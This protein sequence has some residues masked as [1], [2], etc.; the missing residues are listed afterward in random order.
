M[1]NVKRLAAVAIGVATLGLAPTGATA[2]H[3]ADIFVFSGLDAGGQR[4]GLNAG[5]AGCT[6][7]DEAVNTNVITPG[8]THAWVGSLSTV[9]PTGGTLTQGSTSTTLTFTFNTARGRYE[10]QS[11]ALTGADPVTA[12]V[13]T[14]TG[15]ISVTYTHL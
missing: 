1:K 4:Q 10:S 9:V 15:S 11:V 8:A 2:D 14:A 5:S 13:T 3:C 6:V 7:D 12:T